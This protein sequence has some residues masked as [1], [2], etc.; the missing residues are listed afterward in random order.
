MARQR[1]EVLHDGGEVELVECAGEA[2]TIRR[3]F[4]AYNFMV[5]AFGICT[6]EFLP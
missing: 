4:T 6:Y 2:N 5:A 3:K 1:L